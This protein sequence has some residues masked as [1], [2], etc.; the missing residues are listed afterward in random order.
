M[1]FDIVLRNPE[2][3]ALDDPLKNADAVRRVYHIISAGQIR[4]GADCVGGAPLFE[5]AGR[6]RGAG[7]ADHGGLR[8]RIFEA[9]REGQIGDLH[10]FLK[11]GA[12][13]VAGG[14]SLGGK[15][16]EQRIAAALGRQQHRHGGSVVQ[17]GTDILKQRRQL[18]SPGGESKGLY[19]GESAEPQVGNRAGKGVEHRAAPVC[20]LAEQVVEGTDPAVAAREGDSRFKQLGG[21]LGEKG[22]CGGKAFA[23]GGRIRE[24]EQP[25]FRE[26]VEQGIG[27]AVED[28]QQPV[29]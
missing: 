7:V 22:S 24:K 16:A 1:N 3:L 4:E 13:G 10:P 19:A 15:I 2:H 27:P 8:S 17:V 6:G 14:D 21:F 11:G 18:A 20:R 25:V 12:F 5:L 23:A 28:R 9:R 26:V 29:E